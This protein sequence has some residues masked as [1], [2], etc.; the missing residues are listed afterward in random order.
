MRSYVVHFR[1]GMVLPILARNPF[2]AMR[3]FLTE[4]VAKVTEA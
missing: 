4:T 2:D 3:H 1:S